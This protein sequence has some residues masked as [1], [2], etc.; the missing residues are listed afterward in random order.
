[1]QIPAFPCTIWGP[2]AGH[3]TCLGLSLPICKVRAWSSP[4]CFKESISGLSELP[5]TDPRHIPVGGSMSGWPEAR[6]GVKSPHSTETHQFFHVVIIIHPLVLLL[7]QGQERL[8]GPQEQV[9][10]P[11]RVSQ[12][13]DQLLME[14]GVTEHI[15]Q[16]V[17][18]APAPQGQGGGG[19][20]PSP[21]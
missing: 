3:W 1:M 6:Q 12:V 2:R 7:S 5:P 19:E 4:F 15:P 20:L 11:H 18:P 9:L 13:E 21:G 10:P 8:V 14:K 17:P 16:P